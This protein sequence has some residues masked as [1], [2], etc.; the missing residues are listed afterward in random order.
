MGYRSLF[1]SCLEVWPD[2]HM[3]N[4]G[5][6]RSGGASADSGQTVSRSLSG[7]LR[8]V[9]RSSIL[10]LK[11]GRHERARTPW[12]FKADVADVSD[13]EAGDVVG[14]VDSGGAL[15]GQCSSCST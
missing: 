14:V 15:R 5:A 12:I 13:V 9:L 6:R 8:D 1:V 2:A 11:R 7:K 10:R 3:C 4:V